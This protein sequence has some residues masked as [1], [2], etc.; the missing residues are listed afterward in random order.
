MLLSHQ[1]HLINLENGNL[2]TAFTVSC[3]EVLLEGRLGLSDDITSL[4]LAFL[5]RLDLFIDTFEFDLKD[6]SWETIADS[7]DFIFNH[8]TVLEG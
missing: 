5:L 3:F 8:T 4:F 1:V 7:P 6:V 2:G